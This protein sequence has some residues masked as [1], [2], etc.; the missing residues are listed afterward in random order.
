M[1]PSQLSVVPAGTLVII[2]GAEDKLGK[3]TVLSRF[4][5]LAGG[6]DARIA[7]CATA[8]SLGD[9]VTRL[10]DTVFRGLG[11]AEVVS[12]SPQT[13]AEADDPGL[14]RVLD[15][16]TAVFLSGGNQI[17]LS[18]VVTG[19]AFGDAIVGP[20]P[21]RPYGRRH[22]GRR[23][24]HERAH[25]GLRDARGDP[26]E[27]DRAA[28]PRASACCRTWSSTSTSTSATATGGC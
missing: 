10:Y 15:Q 8:S 16:A 4:V 23:Q 2:G 25:G 7:V 5:A 24:R 21:G 13:R 20:A 1:P 17:K 9:E 14:A 12:V 26:E 6:A 28:G 18:Q 11:A 3:S 19:T 27:P 22:L